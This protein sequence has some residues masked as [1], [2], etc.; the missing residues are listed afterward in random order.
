MERDWVLVMVREFV[1]VRDQKEAQKEPEE[2]KP[3]KIFFT[4]RAVQ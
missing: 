4:T 1:M 2:N 3:I